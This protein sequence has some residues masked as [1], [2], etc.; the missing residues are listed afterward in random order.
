MNTHF[1]IVSRITFSRK[2]FL[3]AG[4]VSVQKM[5]ELCSK[6]PTIRDVPVFCWFVLFLWPIYRSLVGVAGLSSQAKRLTVNI[7]Y[8]TKMDNILD[9][10]DLLAA[11]SNE[12]LIIIKKRSSQNRKKER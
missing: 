6:N 2:S 5:F 7:S 9:N 12:T 3:L 8:S 4:R 1:V 10:L 11:Y